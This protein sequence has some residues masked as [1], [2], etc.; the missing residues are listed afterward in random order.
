MLLEAGVAPASACEYVGGHPPGDSEAVRGLVAAWEVATD[1]GAPL[2]QT[3]HRFAASLRAIA[4]NERDARTALAG[5]Q[6]TTRLMMVLP[7]VGVLFGF[8]LGF[9][10]IGTLFTTVPGIVCFVVGVLLVL[11]ARLW[12][13]RMLRAA[14]APTAVPG[15]GFDLVA[16]AV[17]GGASIPRA[18]AAVRTAQHAHR[19]TPDDVDEILSLSARA[20]VPA[21]LL[22]RSAAEQARRE[23]RSAG[24]RAAER[25]SVMLMLPL[26]ICV[27]PAFMLLA[28][29]PML[30]SVVG[31]TVGSLTGGA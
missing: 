26:G 9:D 8:A 7:V 22:L 6:A 16:I 10:T 27:L 28:V 2:A 14:R 30:I 18:L 29:A 25:L 12:S 11:L 1:A 24:Q 4:D 17:S 3:L 20:G 13:R 19:L 23:A 15:L 31:S 21:A 5:P